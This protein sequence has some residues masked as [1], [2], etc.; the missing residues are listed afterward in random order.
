MQTEIEYKLGR[1]RGKFCAEW[2]D[3]DGQR[4]RASLGTDDPAK[5]D[6]ALI[7]FKAAMAKANAPEIID[8]AHI[9]ERYLNEHIVISTRKM[10]D[11]WERCIKPV[12]GHLRPDQITADLCKTYVAGR[13][14]PEIR[15]KDGTLT[16]P[17]APCKPETV[18]KEL[19]VL[20]NAFGWAGGSKRHHG[21]KELKEHVAGVRIWLPHPGKPKDIRLTREQFAVIMGRKMQRHT[22]VFLLTALATA[23]RHSAILQC[24]WSEHVDLDARVIDFTK[25]ID[26]E[27]AE[28]RKGRAVVG[29]NDML[30]AALVQAKREA[31]TDFVVEYS[32]G[33]IK[34]AK[35]AI[36]FLSQTTGIKF[37]PHVLRHTAATWMAEDGVP[38]ETISQMLGHRDMNTTYRVYARFTPAYKAQAAKALNVLQVAAA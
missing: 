36:T 15:R 5:A 30:Y 33:P 19:G 24:R 27:F 8:T 20:R 14:T 34:S 13:R 22:R 9:V 2:K 11:Y 38:L 28:R 4:H 1:H 26:D 6:G 17:S 37:T 16:K 31:V 10:R 23:A 12:F 32:G 21:V 3:A 7:D 25:F 18:I 29:I 35:K